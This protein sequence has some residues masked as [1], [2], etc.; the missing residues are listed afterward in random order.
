MKTVL[1]ACVHNAGRS[2]M[3]AAWFNAMSDP[4]KARAISAGTQP[5]PGVH[6]EVLVTMAEVGIDLSSAKPQRLTDDLARQAM[7]LV[8][9]GC[10]EV[11]PVVPGL[12]REDWP[13]EDPKGK[14]VERVRQIRDAV[15]ARVAELVSREGW[16]AALTGDAG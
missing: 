9:M 5:G 2:Q 7:L 16:A 8:T 1:F 15:R 12:R 11:C 4:S 3:A 6:P 10:G 14:P 13:L